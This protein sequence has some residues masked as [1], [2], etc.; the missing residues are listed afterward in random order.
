M[1]WDAGASLTTLT[2]FLP[3]IMGFPHKSSAKMQP[4]DQM[5]TAE[6]YLVAPSSNSGGLLKPC[7]PINLNQLK[8]P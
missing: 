8:E 2:S 3:N 6:P 1:W 4:A 5:S 7:Q